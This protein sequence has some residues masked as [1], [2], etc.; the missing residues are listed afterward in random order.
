MSG[1]YVICSGFVLLS[2]FLERVFIL[3]RIGLLFLTMM[4]TE[5]QSEALKIS[6]DIFQHACRLLILQVRNAKILHEYTPLYY[7]IFGLVQAEEL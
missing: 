3:H 6:H 5:R 2:F 1:F 4:I 7:G